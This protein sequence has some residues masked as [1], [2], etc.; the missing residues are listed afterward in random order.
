MI[1]FT[2]HAS[3][4]FFFLFDSHYL[5]CAKAC[6]GRLSDTSTDTL[7]AA[8][9]LQSRIPLYI[10][11]EVENVAGL[12]QKVNERRTLT[13][14]SPASNFSPDNFQAVLSSLLSCFNPNAA[15]AAAAAAASSSSGVVPF[16]DDWIERLMTLSQIP[17]LFA[18]VSGNFG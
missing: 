13:L 17:S 12:T 4:S 1:F 2:C 7:A 18:D 8:Q 15:A 16:S 14:L 11:N 10:I 6:L 5:R 3:F 9:Q